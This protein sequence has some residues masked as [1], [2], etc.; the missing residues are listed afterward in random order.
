MN[1]DKDRPDLDDVFAEL[2]VE[3]VIWSAERTT[4]GVWPQADGDGGRR[5]EFKGK[6]G[7]KKHLNMIAS[8][9]EEGNDHYVKHYS[10]NPHVKVSGD[11]AEA[12]QEI[13]IFHTDRSD[14]NAYYITGH[15]INTL[16]RDSHG[17]WKF[18][19]KTAY[20]EDIAEWQAMRLEKI[21]TD[22]NP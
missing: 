8:M 14:Q 1:R 3:G 9:Y 16:V 19:T 22:S 21:P 7:V 20:V 18:K 13:L 17:K 6:E 10:L 15:Y 11:T 2:Y 4:H 5:V 12:R